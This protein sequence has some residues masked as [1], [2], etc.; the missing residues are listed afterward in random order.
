[1][2]A[3]SECAQALVDELSLPE[4]LP[5]GLSLPHP[6]TTGKIHKPQLRAPYIPCKSAIGVYKSAPTLHG[7]GTLCSVIPDIDMVTSSSNHMRS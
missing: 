1:M 3:V 7:P 2:D 6:L 5:L 4:A